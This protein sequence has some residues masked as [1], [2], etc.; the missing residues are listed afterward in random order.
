MSS[1]QLISLSTR[2]EHDLLVLRLHLARRWSDD[3]LGVT[4]RNLM[5]PAVEMTGTRY[6]LFDVAEVDYYSGA[7]LSPLIHVLRLV[8]REREGAVLLCN[9]SESGRDYLRLARLDTV[10]CLCDDEP[11]AIA[12]VAR[13]RSGSEEPWRWP[14]RRTP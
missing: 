13:F 5:L 6:V 4:L 2:P 11:A 12:Q 8:V 3:E 7:L 9:L 1:S 14:P 10:F